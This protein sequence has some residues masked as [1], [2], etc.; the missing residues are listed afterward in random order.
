MYGTKKSPGPWRMTISLRVEPLCPGCA[1]FLQPIV[2]E[3]RQGWA[4]C[5][6]CVSSKLHLQPHL[7]FILKADP[8]WKCSTLV[9]GIRFYTPEPIGGKIF[10]AY[11][12]YEAGNAGP[13]VPTVP[14]ESEGVYALTPSGEHALA[15]LDVA[16]LLGVERDLK[17]VRAE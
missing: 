13:D 6:V 16:G 5:A 7:L 11:D 2:V 1:Q 4:W 17:S 8:M 10:T 14:D 12:W 9:N 15:D 3:V